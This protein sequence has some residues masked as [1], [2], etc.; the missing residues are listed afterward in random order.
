MPHATNDDAG[1]EGA[2]YGTKFD[3]PSLAALGR[4]WTAALDAREAAARATNERADRFRALADKPTRALLAAAA[5]AGPLDVDAL[6][7]FLPGLAE[8]V[9]AGTAEPAEALVWL[10][11]ADQ[12][13]APNLLTRAAGV[14]AAA[15]ADDRAVDLL[16]RAVRAHQAGAANVRNDRRGSAGSRSIR[17]SRSWK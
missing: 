4:D 12:L 13:G 11:V 3:A 14:A 5:E 2:Y 8:L 15:R 6:W 9:R 16:V 17:S 7:W 1:E 10:D